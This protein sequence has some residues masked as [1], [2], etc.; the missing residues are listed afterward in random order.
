MMFSSRYAIP[1]IS[2]QTVE[3]SLNFTKLPTRSYWLCCV[4]FRLRTKC[5]LSTVSKASEQ[6]TRG[7]GIYPHWSKF[8][9]LNLFLFSPFK[10]LLLMLPT[11][12][13]WGNTRMFIVSV[14]LKVEQQEPV[15]G[16]K[17]YTALQVVTNVRSISLS[18]RCAGTC[19]PNTGTEYYL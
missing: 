7:L 19:L 5:Q 15:S 18:D 17:R 2:G 8:F 14:E 1:W 6:I 4:G 13:N 10:P 9:L 3:V 12:Y 16:K 11:L